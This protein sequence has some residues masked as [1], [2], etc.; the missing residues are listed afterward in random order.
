MKLGFIGLGAMGLPMAR[1]L[2][3]AGH[4][5]T[6]FNRTRSRAEDLR[7]A[8]ATVAESVEDAC[9]AGIVFTMLAD[10]RAA[11]DV[12][13]GS[14]RFF[15]ALGSGGIHVSM[16]TIS[17]ALAQRLSEAHAKAGSVFFSAPVFGRPDSAAARTLSIIAAGPADA[18]EKLRPAFEAMSAK[19]LDAGAVPSHANLIKVCGNFILLSG[20]A[21]LAECIAVVR[22]QGLDP[23]RYLEVMGQTLFTAP[24]YQGYGA[25]MLS[26]KFEPA[27][28]KLRLGLK[29]VSLFTSLGR[30]SEKNLPCAGTVQSFFSRAT[31]DGLGEADV[32]ALVQ[33]VS[34]QR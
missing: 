2:L 15:D 30:Q 1:S 7:A 19:I 5:V 34:A 25:R 21:S 32:S 14:G 3:A 28:F 27:G 20:I 16:S 22:A 17:V 9:R 4:E 31:K 12:V 8:G 13:F 26:G 29:D 6:V 18:R 24:F 33:A 10:D 11:E 23:A